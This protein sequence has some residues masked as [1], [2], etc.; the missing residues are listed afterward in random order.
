MKTPTIPAEAGD[1][2]RTR[3]NK[4][5]RAAQLLSKAPAAAHPVSIVGIGASS[6]GLDAAQ[7]LIA[8]LPENGGMAFILVQH[9]DPTHESM[10]VDLLASHTQLSVVQA[11]D[12]L[13]IRAGQFY[14]IPPGAN[15]AVEAGRLRLSALT[16]RQGARLPFD[17][18]LRSI[19]AECGAHGACIV[20][21]GTGADGAL[22]VRAVKDAGGLVIAQNPKEA[23]FDGMPQSAVATGAVD[24]ILPLA[25]MPGA[26]LQWRQ[27][28]AS[29]SAAPAMTESIGVDPFPDEILALLRSKT[30]HDFA[31]YKR[32]T[33]KR[34]LD[35]RMATVGFGSGDADR[36]IEVLRRDDAELN[37]LASEMLIN[38]TRFFR[39]SNVFRLLEETIIPELIAGAAA[40]GPLRVWVPGCSSGEE[41]YS[42]AM[43]LL[44]QIE[45]SGK[46]VKLQIFASDSDPDAVARARDGIYP[47]TIASDVSAARLERF[48]TSEPGTYRIAPELRAA[49][50]FTVQ[51]VLADPP[52]S[53][54]DLISCRNLLIYLGGEAQ[55]KV[56]SL[57]D[58]ALRTGGVLVLGLSETIAFADDRFERLSKPERVFR[59]IS[60][61]RSPVYGLTRTPS[62][63]QRPALLIGPQLDPE[64]HTALANLCAQVIEAHYAPASAL[65]NRKFECLFT[66]G[67]I[68]RYLRVAP[69]HS[70]HD[71]LAMARPGLRTTLRSIVHRTRQDGARVIASSRATGSGEDLKPFRIE[72]HPLRHDDVDLILLCFVDE[73]GDAPA[74]L[75]AAAQKTSR[76]AELE[77]EI[78]ATRNELLSVIRSLEVSAEE[79]KAIHE[80]ALSVNE[81]F[82]STNEELLTSKEELQSL[83][84]ELTSLNVQMLETLELQRRT[85]ND[86]QNVLYST[87]VA[88]LFLDAELKI[89]FFT[90]A[91]KLLFNV[92]AGDV[93]RPLSDLTTLAVDR[94]LS[95]DAR[96]VLDNHTSIGRELSI[97][98]G[99]TFVRRVLP[100]RETENGV[101]RVS[102]VVI[103]YTDITERKHV[104][105]LLDAAK[106]Q[107]DVANLAK[108][109]F[110]AAASHDLRQPL[111]TL[112]LLL[113]LLES[114]E[115]S[116]AVSGLLTRFGKTLNS[117][118][119]MLNTLLDL[120]HI[121]ARVVRPERSATRLSTLFARMRDQFE[122]Q[123]EHLG[124]ELRIAPTSLLVETDPR[125]LEQ[126][127]HNLVSNALK[128]TQK[129]RVLIG[130]RRRAGRVRIE[131]WD[132]GVGIAKAEHEAVF[133]EHYQVSDGLNGPG[134]GLGLGLAIVQ[135]LGILLS[136]R[137]GIK[138]AIG[139]GSVF[140]IEVPL[141]DAGTLPPKSA[142][143]ALSDAAARTP[144]AIVVIEDDPDVREL[145]GLTLAKD[146]YSVATAANSATALDKIRKTAIMPDL[147]IAD[148]NLGRGDNGLQAAALIQEKLGTLIPV[149]V[150]TGDI[151]PATI[152][153]IEA[154]QCVRLNKPVSPPELTKVVQA[155]LKRPLPSMNRQP[156]LD[157]EAAAASLIYVVD[158][159]AETLDALG[160]VLREAGYAV[161]THLSCESFLEVHKRGDG[162][163]L[164]ID[165][166]LPGLSGVELL[167]RLRLSG[168][169]LPAIMVTGASDIRIAVEVMKQGASDFLEKPVTRIELLQSVAHAI[170]DS[171]SED[172]ASGRKID[173]RA[174]LS[175]LT[176]R[177]L[178]VMELVLAGAPSKN[179]AA[180]LGISQRTV[181]N[182]RAAIMK[183]TGS[184][185][186]PALARLAMRAG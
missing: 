46:D 56:L 8:V 28:F 69:G 20:L 168:D 154:K 25:E 149:I 105:D 52:F 160:Q 79:Q 81:E 107:A 73:P 11:A 100:Y 83:N 35:L 72:A 41:A 5:G 157:V 57:F 178:E 64:P 62:G 44:E 55:A 93:G 152:R 96:L 61:S 34:R 19:A 13:R 4:P 155:L 106:K 24:Q 151:T 179:I 21:S 173:A 132:T 87:E 185:S 122:L 70:T 114:E 144:G 17:H 71:L 138:S 174:R 116:P 45:K 49:V 16:Q 176:P 170:A 141:A 75:A 50:V 88:T 127:L 136:H 108:S 68:D 10:M 32:G 74:A 15:L 58:F 123:A 36:Y 103:T 110:L 29:G 86:L 142:A 23:A 54:L 147:I 42:I 77:A 22:G 65:I 186:I 82:Q 125:L 171:R 166:Y 148:Y 164:I 129:G 53:R 18:L 85:S 128:Y 131:V 94:E 137:I 63:P 158:D 135:R 47:Q 26:L 121:E 31:P 145:L 43:L 161:R 182:H 104:A 111:Q 9:L 101:A 113:G 167:K 48:F 97:E 30:A 130:C 40:Q 91:T 163:C 7:K 3:R 175:M 6:G 162:A 80:E 156:E 67:P 181:E 12:G 150:L 89:R 84:E 60:R 27:S 98:S 169:L 33:L 180:D 102:G 115:T 37:A 172:A 118:S 159:D 76:V 39:D 146:G 109:K 2:R 51:D 78:E 183:K 119:T 124:L 184:A 14:V 134:P 126:M 99:A 1:E 140:S 153:V 117:M 143:S 38:V 177:Q 92:I 120:N 165:A 66:M 90:P 139:R 133:D 112:S 59:K 95:A